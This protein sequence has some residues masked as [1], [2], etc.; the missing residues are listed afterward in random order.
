MFNS[1]AEAAV[2][3]RE[4]EPSPWVRI[5]DLR[6][7]EEFDAGRVPYS[8][9]MSARRAIE[10]LRTWIR[11]SDRRQRVYLFME[12]KQQRDNPRVAELTRFLDE[13]KIV[14][15]FWCSPV[16][17]RQRYDG[18]LLDRDQS[19]PVPWPYPQQMTEGIY[20][21]VLGRTTSWERTATLG[22]CNMLVVAGNSTHTW[23]NKAVDHV[24]YKHLK[25]GNSEAVGIINRVL[26]QRGNTRILIASPK[27]HARATAIVVMYLMCEHK[28]SFKQSLRRVSM[29]RTDL[30][31][32]DVRDLEVYEAKLREQGRVLASPKTTGGRTPGRTPRSARS[33]R[34]NPSSP[35]L[36]F[37]GRTIRYSK[38]SSTPGSENKKVQR[39][40]YSDGKDANN[41]RSGRQEGSPRGLEQRSD[42]KTSAAADGSPDGPSALGEA[43]AANVGATPAAPRTEDSPVGAAPAASRQSDAEREAM[44]A[45]VEDN[46]RLETE[47]TRLKSEYEDLQRVRDALLEEKQINEQKAVESSR[48]AE[49]LR[50][51]IGDLK[52]D[53]AARDEQVIE[54]DGRLRAYITM[55]TEETAKVRKLKER[56]SGLEAKAQSLEKS[57]EDEAKRRA[58]LGHSHGKATAEAERLLEENRN[59][60]ALLDEAK[61]R[62]RA[63]E[64]E[65]RDEASK[66]AQCEQSLAASRKECE[67][68][69]RGTSTRERELETAVRKLEQSL[70]EEQQ[71]AAKCK[72]EARQ[73]IRVAEAA[74]IAVRSAEAKLDK[75]AARVRKLERERVGLE[76]R[77]EGL[78][79]EIA[80]GGL[81][82]KSLE[83]KRAD[84]ARDVQSEARDKAALREALALEKRARGTAEEQLS[85]A[86]KELNK[87]SRQ[88]VKKE[89]ELAT[90]EQEAAKMQRDL[91]AKDQQLK[92]SKRSLEKT[93]KKLDKTS[94]ELKKMGLKL[95]RADQKLASKSVELDSARDAEKRAAK[96]LEVES[97][98]RET[99]AAQL[100]AEKNSG[101]ELA[102][103]LDTERQTREADLLKLQAILDEKASG[104][105]AEDAAQSAAVADDCKVT[106]PG[107]LGRSVGSN[108]ALLGPLRKLS[109]EF[110]ALYYLCFAFIIVFM[111]LAAL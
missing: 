34:S 83:T 62:T 84:L 111:V 32:G 97:Q 64:A 96:A 92:T 19:D 55:C 26:G 54:I 40:L 79:A 39:R 49:E 22:I 87:R 80:A 91:E 14:R 45:V 37:T 48:T 20:V 44:A 58:D 95:A 30:N 99:L 75:S 41:G 31:P 24:Y 98:K 9:H 21:G 77:L 42:A 67:E 69:K 17:Y 7:R 81:R 104:P 101:K 6:S 106:D 86:E 11:Q 38:T 35:S 82:V 70:Q 108:L 8:E 74:A 107:P 100:E 63:V 50:S 53:V 71:R 94:Q 28:L 102:A 16:I 29:R 66:L 52:A 36:V 78:E 85:K 76:K 109:K 89:R 2:G 18:T 10:A 56:L 110:R 72:N 43:A 5:F 93:S 46:K 12:A 73:Q 59:L 60:Q 90:R 65:V 61:A 25:N 13:R 23:K 51:T 105:S 1:L 47:L 57:R 103:Q 68:Y 3:V 33:R 88:V 15:Y 27:S 4:G